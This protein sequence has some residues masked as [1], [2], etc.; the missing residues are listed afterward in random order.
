MINGT[1]LYFE[2]NPDYT[3]RPDPEEILPVLRNIKKYTTKLE[4]R[5]NHEKLQVI[6]SQLLITRR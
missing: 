1:I 6:R 4:F 2:V 5:N 3:R